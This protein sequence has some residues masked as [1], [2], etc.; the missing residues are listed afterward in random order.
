MISVCIENARRT[1]AQRS[2]A[3]KPTGSASRYNSTLRVFH[4]NWDTSVLS[5]KKK[6]CT[7][8][9]GAKQ[10]ARRLTQFKHRQ[11]SFLNTRGQNLYQLLILSRRDIE[12]D[13]RVGLCWRS[14]KD[15]TLLEKF[16]RWSTTVPSLMLCI[17]TSFK[18]VYIY[19]LLCHFILL[20]CGLF[21][22]TYLYKIYESAMRA[23]MES[24]NRKCY[25]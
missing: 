14:E 8:L 2:V 15:V 19:K 5:Y 18:Y 4:T 23:K 21:I 11:S 12:E 10:C 17:K 9:R 25:N 24:P 3:S 20:D 7:P 16:N 6:S 1:P 22:T 13:I